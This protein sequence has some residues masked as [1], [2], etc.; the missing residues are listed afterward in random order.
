MAY[1]DTFFMQHSDDPPPSIALL[2]IV[3]KKSLGTFLV[4]I[5]DHDDTVFYFAIITTIPV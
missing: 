4:C 2:K 1:C 5:H 3:K